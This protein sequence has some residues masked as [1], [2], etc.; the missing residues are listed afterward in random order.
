MDLVIYV[1][2]NTAIVGAI[3]VG[4]IGLVITFGIKYTVVTILKAVVWIMF[5]I[6]FL[7][8]LIVFLVRFLF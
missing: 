4:V 5:P 8:K 2:K 6:V 3:F 1:A 7:I